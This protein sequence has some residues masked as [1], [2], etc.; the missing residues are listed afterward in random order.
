MSIVSYLDIHTHLRTEALASVSVGSLSSDEI[1]NENP[2]KEYSCAGIHPWW[3]EELTAVQ[4]EALKSHILKMIEGGVLWGVGETGLDRQYPEFWE[5]QKE[6]FEW[7]WNL[8]ENYHLPLVLHNV[9]S[10]SDF[11][12]L[13]KKRKPTVPWLF[14]DF[15]G[16]EELVNSLLRLHPECYFSFGISLDN[17]PQVRELLPLIPLQNLFLETDNQKHLD[18]HDIY[19]R[20]SEQLGVDL[21]FLKAQLW[22]NFKKLTPRLQ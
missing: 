1:L 15:R 2:F 7:H 16:N 11:L 21:E 4:I 18:I 12:E 22:H 9:R 20:A 17:S 3:L 5:L 19:L 14:H 13:L 8:A 10:G 6:L